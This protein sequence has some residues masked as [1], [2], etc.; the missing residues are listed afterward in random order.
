VDHRTDWSMVDLPPA[1]ACELIE[2]ARSSVSGHEISP[3]E[4]LEEACGVGNLPVGSPWAEKWRGGPT[5][6]KC[7]G[8]ASL[9]ADGTI[10]V[11][12]REQ[13]RKGKVEGSFY[14]AEQGRKGSLDGRQ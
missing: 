2:A 1:V 7:S 10:C 14:W 11:A 12:K 3:Q 9:G 6:V 4:V 5:A 8:E 13:R